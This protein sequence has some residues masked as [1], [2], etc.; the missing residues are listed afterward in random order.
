MKVKEL[1]AGDIVKQKHSG[2]I[3]KV[4][5]IVPP[6]IRAEGEAGPFHEDTLEPILL[7]SAI[8]VQNG[9]VTKDE[10]D[11]CTRYRS[12]TYQKGSTGRKGPTGLTF[13]LYHDTGKY[14]WS[15]TCEISLNSLPYWIRFKYLHEL[16]NILKICGIDKEIT[17]KEN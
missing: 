12:Y 15:G 3:L 4:S 13:R 8:L 2:L 6:Y 5:A 16:Q 17:I 11:Y 1:M 10:P 7:T 14:E 9:F